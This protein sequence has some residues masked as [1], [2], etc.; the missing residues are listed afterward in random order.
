VTVDEEQKEGREHGADHRRYDRAGPGA[1]GI[2]PDQAD[3]VQGRR[4][5]WRSAALRAGVMVALLPL[6][7]AVIGVVVVHTHLRDRLILDTQ[8]RLQAELTNI[9]ALYDQRRVPAVRQAIEF[10]TLQG[11]DA[12]KGEGAVYL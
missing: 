9:A 1:L 8:A 2:G 10:R 3:T 7:L 4:F 12:Q 6:I 5:P 11:R